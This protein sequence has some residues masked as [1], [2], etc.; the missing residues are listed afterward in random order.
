MVKWGV[1]STVKAPLFEVVKFVAH[2]L[3]MG[4][5][6]FIIY[7]DEP[8]EEIQTFFQDDP[9]V[10]I[11]Q[12]DLD[13]WGAAGQRPK[14]IERRQIFNVNHGIS[15]VRLNRP[16]LE[17]MAHIDIDEYLVNHAAKLT[18]SQ[19]LKRV[20][21]DVHSVQVRPIENLIPPQPLAESVQYFKALMYPWGRRVRLSPTLFPEFGERVI[22]GFLSHKN[23]KT[24]FRVSEDQVYARIHYA[25]RTENE[26][27][28]PKDTFYLRGYELAHFHSKP[29]D[30][31]ES[32]YQERRKSGSYRVLYK[33]KEIKREGLKPLWD[34]FDDIEQAEGIEGIK[35]LHAAVCIATPDLVKRLENFNVLRRYN[36]DFDAKI[37]RYFPDYIVP[38]ARVSNAD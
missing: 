27:R 23:G 24:I 28:D 15:L 19:K 10:L 7:L 5:R 36:F 21:K 22:G 8:N 6:Y 9:D 3:S 20:P 34:V 2:H 18:I 11:I 35:R 30:E 37:Q 4:A 12:T 29:W 1:I 32:L 17:W 16:S 38:Q 26:Q 14:S 33:G 31:F 13:Y 25:T